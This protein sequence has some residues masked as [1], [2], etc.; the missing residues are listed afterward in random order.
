MRHQPISRPV[1][2]YRKKR[3]LTSDAIHDRDIV[4]FQERFSSDEIICVGG[5]N[6]FG[7]N[8]RGCG[9]A[10]R[11]SKPRAPTYNSANQGKVVWPPSWSHC[12]AKSVARKERCVTGYGDRDHSGIGGAT[13]GPASTRYETSNVTTAVALPSISSVQ[14]CRF[15]T[16]CGRASVVPPVIFSI[17]KRQRL[18]FTARFKRGCV[19]LTLGALVARA[20]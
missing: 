13:G 18:P 16:I 6:S 8:D 11:A 20:V 12:A 2:L 10:R 1:P 3:E 14:I 4:W 5:Q 7:N 19:L 9:I 17:C 15:L